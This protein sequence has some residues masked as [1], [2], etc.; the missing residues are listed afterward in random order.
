VICF[1]NNFNYEKAT[2]RDILKLKEIWVGVL[3][4]N[5]NYSG[6]VKLQEDVI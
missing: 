5:V 6:T 1:L 4:L 3:L 2:K